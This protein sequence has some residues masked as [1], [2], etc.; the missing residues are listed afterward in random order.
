MNE[1][2]KPVQNGKKSLVNMSTARLN[3]GTGNDCA[4]ATTAKIMFKKWDD[5][6]LLPDNIL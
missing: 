1:F 3:R 4:V 6:V 5:C 2:L